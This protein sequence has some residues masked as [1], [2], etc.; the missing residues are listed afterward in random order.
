M[1]TFGDS[2]TDSGFAYQLSNH[3]WPPVPPFN[4]E[5]GFSDGPL[6]NQ[7]LTQKFL[8]NATLKNFACGSAT[9]DSQLAQGVMSRNPNLIENYHIRNNTKSPGVRQQ[10]ALYTNSA[11]NQSIDFDRTLY[12]IWTGT[13]NYFFNKTLT[14]L[15]TVQSIMDCLSLLIAFGGRHLVIINEPPFDRFP[16]FR[17]KTETNA[18][19]QLYIDHNTILARQFSKNYSPSMAGR[20]IQL[21]DSYS[22]ISNI[23][24]NYTKYGFENLNSCWDTAMGSSVQVTCLNITKRMFCD[25]YHFTSQMQSFIAEELYYSMA[26]QLN[27]MPN[28]Q[29]TSTTP[30]IA[31]KIAINLGLFLVLFINDFL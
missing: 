5:G 14:T 6:W 12:I 13:N 9:T 31:N 29:T 23:M 22:V 1:I 27:S 17:N 24:E 10:I 21:F 20:N 16:A 28:P 11:N 19:K 25:E 4:S 2:T 8:S 30:S 18:T 3:T 26:K 7:I 15:D